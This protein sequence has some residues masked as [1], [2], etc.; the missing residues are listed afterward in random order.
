MAQNDAL[1]KYLDAGMAFTQ[2]TRKR[3]EQV[4]KDLV[5]AGDLQ[6]SQAKSTI[7][8]LIERTRSNADLLSE[9]VRKEVESQLARLPG[10]GGSAAAKG[11][12]EDESAPDEPSEP[13]AK[14][15]SSTTAPTKPTE[16]TKATK[17]TKATKKAAAS[18]AAGGK[19][20]AA[21]K[22]PAGAGTPGKSTPAQKAANSTK[23]QG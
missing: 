9:Q 4:V 22:A 13:A 8:D 6:R 17:V 1:K 23:K 14:E 21:K 10:F 19:A 18:K 11:G 16:P 20:A 2:L 15:E 5:A 3:A 7:E 12:D